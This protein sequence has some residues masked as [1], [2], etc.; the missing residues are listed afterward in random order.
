MYISQTSVVT[1]W[2]CTLAET[3]VPHT[4]NMPRRYPVLTLRSNGSASYAKLFVLQTS[5]G[6]E[7]HA[8][9]W[10]CTLALNRKCST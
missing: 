9:E 7:R 1:E 8:E 2:V 3:R 6:T 5:A 4:A 10:A